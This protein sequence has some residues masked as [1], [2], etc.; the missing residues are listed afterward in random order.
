MKQ[1]IILCLWILFSFQ[2]LGEETWREKISRR[3]PWSAAYKTE[4]QEKQRRKEFAQ[5][6]VSMNP[7]ELTALDSELRG[8]TNNASTLEE[9]KVLARQEI[10]ARIARNEQ[11]E[12]LQIFARALKARLSSVLNDEKMASHFFEIFQDTARGNPPRAY[13][14]ILKEFLDEN[15]DALRKLSLPKEQLESMAN[16]E[17][18][19]PTAITPLEENLKWTRE[20]A[21]EFFATF[22]ANA[23]GYPSEARRKALRKIFDDNAEYIK[24]LPFSTKQ[25]KRMEQYMSDIEISLMF[26]EGGLERAEGDADKFFAVLKAVVYSPTEA[27]Q[28]AL[29]NFF[30]AKAETIKQLPFSFKQVKYMDKYVDSMKTSIIL[31]EGGL[32]QARGDADKFFAIFKAAVYSPTEE[33]KKA[34]EIFF[35]KNAETILSLGLSTKQIRYMDRHIDSSAVSAKLLEGSFEINKANCPNDMETLFRP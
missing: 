5:K 4:K 12:F 2:A 32:E 19:T 25:I 20:S 15:E 11:D 17:G 30:E 33:Y 3:L 18:Q 28:D 6:L 34:L 29:K 10:Y 21:D 14:N 26:L 24:K 16:Y 22:K 35:L 9:M 23:A 8:N 1:I 7:H 13:R 27:Y 31:L